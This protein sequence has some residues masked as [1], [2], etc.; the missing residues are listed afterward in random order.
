MEQAERLIRSYAAHLAEHPRWVYSEVARYPPRPSAAPSSIHLTVAL[1]DDAGEASGIN[2][3][4]I[5]ARVARQTRL[6]IDPE[7]T[8]VFPWRR[9]GLIIY[10]W[11]WRQAPALP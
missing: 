8:V 1:R 11:D 2:H 10:W 3:E 9:R 4:E 7:Y 6:R 5:A